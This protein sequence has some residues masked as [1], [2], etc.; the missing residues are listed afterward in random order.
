MT[1]LL[2]LLIALAVALLAYRSVRRRPVASRLQEQL[3]MPG[4]HRDSDPGSYDYQRQLRD[5]TAVRSHEEDS[6]AA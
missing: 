3:R 5:I 4:T 6:R 1:T 2:P